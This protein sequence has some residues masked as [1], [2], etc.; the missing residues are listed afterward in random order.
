ML[1]NRSNYFW[2]QKLELMKFNTTDQFKNVSI[3]MDA[4]LNFNSYTKTIMQSA[5]ILRI[6]ELELRDT[7]MLI[8]AFIFP[9]LNYCNSMYTPKCCC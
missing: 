3:V 1:K 9:K 7:K 8:Y 4:D 6:L 5:S 2:S